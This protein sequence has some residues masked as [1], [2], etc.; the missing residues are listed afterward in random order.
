MP[1]FV[2]SISRLPSSDASRLTRFTPAGGPIVLFPPR[3][4]DDSFFTDRFSPYFRSLRDENRN[5]C[6]VRLIQG[7][8]EETSSNLFLTE[9]R[10]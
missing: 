7:D 2:D 6:R 5:S 1:S 9:T 8:R 4:D 10:Q 3:G